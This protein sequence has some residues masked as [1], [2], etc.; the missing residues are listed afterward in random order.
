METQSATTKFAFDTEFAA[1]GTI[2]RDGEEWRL[3]FTRDEMQSECDKAYERGRQDALVKAEEDSAQQMQLLVTQ[4]TEILSTLAAQSTACRAQ[5]IELVL[6][7]AR[8]IAGAAL[9]QFPDER[10]QGALN[11]ILKDLRNTPRLVLTCPTGI[12][13]NAINNLREQVNQSAFDG[14]LIIR[15]TEQAAPGDVTLEWAQGEVCIKTDDIAERVE[16]TVR[17]WLSATE[18]Q[19]AQGDL[20]DDP[21]QHEEG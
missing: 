11:D 21:A 12:T 5:A 15:K 6:I 8:K 3:S 4:S 18:E 9:E 14:E 17:H 20:F 1:D 13:E 2:L 19:E 7:T 10:V 16:K